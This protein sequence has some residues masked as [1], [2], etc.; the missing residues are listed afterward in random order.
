MAGQFLAAVLSQARVKALLS[1]DHFSVDG[2][3]LE[4]WASLKSFRPKAARASHPAPDA[5]ASGTFTASLEP[6]TRTPRPPTR[7]PSH[8]KGLGKEARLC[9]IGHALMENAMVWSSPR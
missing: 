6:M 4:A 5:T 1:S 7:R 8:R 2:T 3:L 9:F